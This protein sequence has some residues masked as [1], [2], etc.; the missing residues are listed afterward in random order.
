MIAALGT[1]SGD[2][3]VICRNPSFFNTV[4][5]QLQL[6]L[7]DI[8]FFL[9]LDGNS[10]RKYFVFKGGVVEDRETHAIRPMTPDIAVSVAA[11][12]CPEDAV[13][14]L[15]EKLTEEGVDLD[16]L[17]TR[18][19]TQEVMGAFVSGKVTALPEGFKYSPDLERDLQKVAH[20]VKAYQVIGNCHEESPVTIS[21][22]KHFARAKYAREVFEEILFNTGEGK[23][24]K[25]LVS[26]ILKVYFGEYCCEPKPEIFSG[27][28]DPNGVSPAFLELRGRR[29][30]LLT[31]AEAGAKFKAGLLKMLRDQSTELKARGLYKGLVKFSPQFLG[32]FA[33]NMDFE[34]NAID[35]GVERSFTGL[36]WPLHFKTA[37][38]PGTIERRLENIKTESYIREHLVPGLDLLLR[39]VDTHLLKDYA[40]TVVLPRP[41]AVVQ[42][43]ATL[44]RDKDDAALDEFMGKLER[45]GDWKE[46][47]TR[48]QITKAFVN[49]Y[50]ISKDKAPALL[51]KRFRETKRHGRDLLQ[52]KG[53]A[54]FAKLM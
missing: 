5:E 15:L 36:N 26:T 53:E 52:Y 20:V 24:G 50:G 45:E 2:L 38:T 18:I 11:C 32:F 40:E 16:N 54:S 29:L 43:T 22:L 8:D 7:Y 46:A 27:H 30:V 17:M 19:Q 4:T 48:P 25:G 23:N 14:V 10:M 31:D 39:A 9:R 12:E 49:D 13:K 44:H 35:G 37:P 21:L 28:A 34:F 42:A 41:H 3:P 47:S 1:W 33:A 51:K 6:N